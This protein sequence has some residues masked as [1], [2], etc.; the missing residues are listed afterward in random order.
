MNRKILMSG[1]SIVATISLFAGVTYAQLTATAAGS[2][3]TFAAESAGLEIAQDNNGTPVDGWLSTQDFSG[4]INN[5]FPGFNKN[6]TFWLFNNSGA[7][8]PLST[9]VTLKTPTYDP[10]DNDL[11]NNLSVG[12]NCYDY[13]TTLPSSVGTIPV[14]NAD[15]A[16]SAWGSETL[17]TLQPGD[18][19]Y[20]AMNASVPA[21]VTS[22]IPGEK[23]SFTANFG[24]TQVEP[25]P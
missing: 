9:I 21:N 22:L 4:I 3:I 12:F 16:L 17:P 8:I 1:I 23:V 14:T 13:G 5:V 10:S 11:N 19:A 24:G 6:I 18:Y 2:G 7:D 15:Y 25:T 20:C